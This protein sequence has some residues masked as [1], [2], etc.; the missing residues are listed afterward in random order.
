MA[1]VVAR[2]G[3]AGTAGARSGGSATGGGS[4]GSG[5]SGVTKPGMV[6]R[7]VDFYHGVMAEMRK[8]TWPDLPQVR[9]ATIAIIIF[10][11]L[12]GLAITIM[13]FA[14]QGILIKGIPSLF[15]GR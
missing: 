11:L 15:A 7:L 1:D 3:A 14:L 5:G 13:D 8:V 6:A 2:P 9:S 4:G 10:V 12:L